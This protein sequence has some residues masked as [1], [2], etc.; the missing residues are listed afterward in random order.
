MKKITTLSI[1]LFAT[2]FL[3]FN[4]YGQSL[5]DQAAELI[6]ANG[7][8][9]GQVADISPTLMGQSANKNTYRVFCDDGTENATYEMEVG[10]GGS[11]VKIREL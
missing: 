3:S 11:Y 4:A 2:S 6:R 7:Y 1:I 5:K 8:W 10:R 9:C